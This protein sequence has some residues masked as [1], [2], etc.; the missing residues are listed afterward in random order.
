MKTRALIALAFLFSFVSA[1]RK[2]SNETQA[3]PDPSGPSDSIYLDKIY[4]AEITGNTLDTFQIVAF[5]YD[6]LKRV[7]SMVGYSKPVGSY[8]DN[9]YAYF[10]NGN[11]TIPFKTI[12]TFGYT[13]SL[14]TTITYHSFDASL[15]KIKDSSIS[16][17]LSTNPVIYRKWTNVTN[18]T[19]VSDKIFAYDTKHDI[20]PSPNSSSKKDTATIDIRNNVVSSKGY[21]SIFG[22][23]DYEHQT[24]SNYTYDNKPNPFS[25]LSNYK[26]HGVMPNGETLL[27]DYFPKN[28][29][30]IQN[31]TQWG[32]NR[33]T[34]YAYIFNAHELPVS[35]TLTSNYNTIISYTYRNF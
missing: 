28:N 29:V 34:N 25:I 32:T 33:I 13:F 11:D 15:R 16:T 2:E 27:L 23:N 30:L 12:R 20:L 6:N 18:Y 1:C 8:P 22:A 7:T 5:T 14:D 3:T 31:E 10:Y 17:R 4:S 24:T 19:Y 35:A 26:A 9:S 21:F